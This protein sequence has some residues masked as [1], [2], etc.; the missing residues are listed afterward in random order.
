M[1]LEHTEPH[2][3]NQAPRGGL[4]LRAMFSTDPV[5]ACPK[6][7]LVCPELRDMDHDTAE[8]FLEIAKDR[9]KETLREMRKASPDGTITCYFI[10]PK[11]GYK[12]DRIT[13]VGDSQ[14][15]LKIAQR[16]GDLNM[17]Q[18]KEKEPTYEPS[19]AFKTIATK[20]LLG[21]VYRSSPNR[22]VVVAIEVKPK[23]HGLTMN[24]LEDT[25]AT[26][27]KR[28]NGQRLEVYVDGTRPL[29]PTHHVL[30]LEGKLKDI[31]TIAAQFAKCCA[32]NIHHLK[33]QQASPSIA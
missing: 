33:E 12:A 23:Y 5:K 9:I 1:T 6:L 11:P 19:V 26:A 15:L 32:T 7:E 3:K 8:G 24:Q 2:D 29:D 16:H 17:G 31:D 4:Q 21:E 20:E 10:Q 22:H 18:P 28:E 30:Y 25:I 14:L 27:T 13:L